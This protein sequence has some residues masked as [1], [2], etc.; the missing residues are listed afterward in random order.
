MNVLKKRLKVDIVMS[1]DVEK[2]LDYLMRTIFLK[3]AIILWVSR[4]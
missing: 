1:D 3:V 4:V 2:D